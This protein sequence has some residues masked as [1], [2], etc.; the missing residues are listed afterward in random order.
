MALRIALILG[1]VGLALGV[2]VE[3][4]RT[5]RAKSRAE[6][7]WHRVTGTVE[8]L[9]DSMRPDVKVEQGIEFL[10]P[11]DEFHGPDERRLELENDEGLRRFH[12]YEFLIDPVT[13]RARVAGVRFT[14]FLLALLGLVYLGIAG[15][16]YFV[17]KNSLT[18]HGITL[19]LGPPGTW[20]HFQAP[21]W[22]EPA[23]V[24]ARV[25]VWPVF[26]RALGAAIGVFGFVMLR[27]SRVESLWGRVGLA[28]VVLFVAGV[29]AVIT[30][31]RAT[32]HIEAD[33]T[34]LR[35]SS[36]F[37]WKMTPWQ[38][39]HGAVDEKVYH[40]RRMGSRGSSMT[41]DHID[42]RVYFTDDQGEEVVSIDDKLV[43]EQGK[44]LLA[45]VLGR[46]GLQPQKREIGKR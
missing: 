30:L 8:G 5:V 33:S 13:K 34:G 38:A 28:S 16:F 43:A 15:A 23:I 12:R 11:R 7:E 36:A 42:H 2:W 22:H 20:T 35:E 26:E 41:L 46:T 27:T 19:P 10:P 18:Y 37:G 32:Y 3:T 6:R 4:W 24:A 40:Y 45:H 39:L 14:P 31:D 17:T 44:A 25:A 9:A 1:M 21:P 29:F